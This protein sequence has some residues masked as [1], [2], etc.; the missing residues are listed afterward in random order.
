MSKRL[1][2][3]SAFVIV[4]FLVLLPFSAD[5]VVYWIKQGQVFQGRSGEWDDNLEKVMVIKDGSTFKMWYTG[6]ESGTR[7]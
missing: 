4:T 3:L 2:T 7:R 5:A 1:K 6:E